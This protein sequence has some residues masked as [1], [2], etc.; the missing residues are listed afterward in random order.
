MGKSEMMDYLGR[1]AGVEP[2]SASRFM[3]SL[4]PKT[5]AER[6]VPLLLDALDE[7]MA[8]SEGDAVDKVLAR[9]EDAGRPRFILAC[10]AREWQSRAESELKAIY[11]DSPLVVSI[12]D[13]SRA[14]ARAFWTM[15]AFRTDSTAVLDRMDEQNLSDLYKNP[16]TLILLGAVADSGRGVPRTR[17]ELLEHVCEL[18][19]QEH[20]EAKQGIPLARLTQTQALSAAGAMMASTILSGA[21]A[22]NLTSAGASADGDLPIAEVEALPG[23]AAARAVISSKLFKTVGKSR[24]SPIHRV[25]AEFLGAK[26]LA[27]Q[28]TTS[29]VQRRLIAQFQGGGPVPS[30]LRGMHA[31]LA[32]HSPP[33]AAAVISADPF[34]LL[35]YGE[36]SSLDPAQANA[37]L[38]SLETLASS[39]PYFRAQ[40]WNART[41]FAFAQ[42]ALV[43]RLQLAITDPGRNFHLRM[44]ILESVKGSQIV[45]QLSSALESVLLG[46]DRFYAEREIAAEILLPHRSRDYWQAVVQQLMEERSEDSARLSLRLAKEIEYD[47]PD[48][49]LAM[50]LL[51]ELDL[52]DAPTLEREDRRPLR[53]HRFDTLVEALEPCR[54]KALLR[55]LTL[56]VSR[57]YLEQSDATSD[58]PK[59]AALLLVRALQG[60]QVSIGDVPALWRWLEVA[61]WHCRYDDD[62]QKTLKSELRSRV[63]LRRSTQRYGIW[64]VNRFK[65]LVFAEHELRARSI[66]LAADKNDVAFF[67]REIAKAKRMTRRRRNDW[68]DLVDLG[69]RVGEGNAL[70]VCAAEGLSNMSMRQ[71]AHLHMIQRPRKYRWQVEQEA[72]AAKSALAQKTRQDRLNRVY[73]SKIPEVRRGELKEICQPA[74]FYLGRQ[75]W[76]TRFSEMPPEHRL[77]DSFN[78]RL[79]NEFMNGFEA[80]LHRSDLP[81]FADLTSSYAAG[82]IYNYSY[83]LIAGLLAR[84]RGGVALDSVPRDTLRAGLLLSMQHRHTFGAEEYL[85]AIRLPVELL[86]VPSVEDKMQFARAWIEPS[87]AAGRPAEGDIQFMARRPGWSEAGHRLASEWLS[88]FLDTSLDTELEILS[89]LVNAGDDNAIIEAARERDRSIYRNEEHAL[90]WLAIDVA[91]R[92]DEVRENLAGIGL[93]SPEFIWRLR[94]RVQSGRRGPI[95]RLPPRVLRWIVSEFRG[96]YPLASRKGL[97]VGTQ[98]GHDASEFIQT[99]LSR[100]ADDTGDESARLMR[101]LAE[102]PKDHYTDSI[103]HMVAEQ[104]QKRAEET[105]A[106]L[107]PASLAAVLRNGPPANIDDL[108]SLIVDELHVAQLKLLGDE[109]DQVRDFWGDDEVPYDENRCRDRLVA[110]IDTRLADMYSVKRMTEADMPKDKRA[111]IAFAAGSSLQLPV[112]VKGQWHTQVWDA[113]SSQLE[114]Q[115]L[116]DWRSEGRGLY[117]I[118]WFGELSASTGRRLKS[119]PDGLPVPTNSFQMRSMVIDRIPTARRPFID[120]IVLDLATGRKKKEHS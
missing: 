12:E 80:V 105:F 82:T 74:Q 4:N 114:A 46:P 61:S 3:N 70:I 14:E 86:V 77:S 29:Q 59:L 96:P 71:M 57:V 9:L 64:K 34:G 19:W 20:D 33:L 93:D 99:L 95:S 78:S 79:A 91:Y 23:G 11:G 75:V 17:A 83:P 94:D 41:A 76:E 15:R 43:S 35:R 47:L 42:P 100:L 84:V 38:D 118:F 111:D 18:S 109:L 116:I 67:L 16:L 88:R 39:D 6:G 63:D 10:R 37:L 103:R 1:Q 21:E 90:V 68:Q 101:E 56:A 98:N 117:C 62:L 5:F 73:E 115:Y 13:L 55:Y 119:H 87:L 44:L 54:A 25:V 66:P 36:S 108:R 102:E 72:A 53:V 45:E 40:D 92:F 85:E 51:V 112:E 30:S 106:P 27:D 48:D 89:M 60:Q 107:G 8:R 120:V 81:S 110:L 49:L 52:L 2:I 24:A 32:F 22:I 104:R 58:F 7:A 50:A 69:V 26:W 31:W 28:A 97:A 113:A 65:R